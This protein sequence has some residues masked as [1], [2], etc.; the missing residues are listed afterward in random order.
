MNI[1]QKGIDLIKSFEGLELHSYQDS[2]NVWTIGYGHTRNVQKGESITIEQANEFLNQD[3]SL[4]VD[5]VNKLV[6]HPIN[7]N[8]FDALVSFAYNLGTGC[9]SESSLLKYVNEGNF[10]LAASQFG[11][12]DHAGG[13]VIEGLVKRRAEEMHLF[14]TPVSDPSTVEKIPLPSYKPENAVHII[15][16]GETLSKIALK[17]QVPM[18]IL[19]KY[20]QLSDPNV[21]KT[22]ETLHIPNA[23]EVRSGDTLTEIARRNHDLIDVISY[24]NSIPE[25]NKIYIGQKLWV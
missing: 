1:S 8:Q 9:L 15:K 12:Y 5:E 20:N 23:I 16:A 3:L 7:Q 2:A 10:K 13:E 18:N 19:V 11:K 17:Y 24:V 21:I 22:G 25:K 4:F 6:K 14:L